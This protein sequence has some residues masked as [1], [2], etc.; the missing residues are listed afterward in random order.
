MERG[1]MP[2]KLK[3]FVTNLG[4]FELAVAAPSMKAALEAWG[5]GHNAFKHGFAKQTEDPRI[6]EAAEAAPGTV[7]RRPIGSTGAFKEQSDLPKVAD[8]KA[9]AR[10]S[11]KP[12]KREIAQV[13]KAK[14]RAEPQA[15]PPMIDLEAARR[16]REKSEKK[17]AKDR[18]RAEAQAAR[19]RA[20]REQAVKKAMTALS[21]A[22]ARHE[23][24]LTD[25][26]RKRAALDAQAEA[27]NAH[28]EKERHRLEA[29]LFKA[30]R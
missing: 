20:R 6:V 11:S 27:E 23:K 13:G 14:P 24:I 21:S 9:A 1:A 30:K 12:A 10:A 26:E 15:K 29:E 22:R 2:R 28:W 7:L 3:T 16:A 18:D 5:L 17:E 25:I 8:V 19:E 4:F